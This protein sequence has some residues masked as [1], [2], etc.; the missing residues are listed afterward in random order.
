MTEYKID[1]PKYIIDRFIWV[2]II[3]IFGFFTIF[4]NNFLTPTNMINVMLHAS[5]LGL[6][7]IG[8]AVCLI[9][10]NFDLSAEGTVA[11]LTVLAAWLMGTAGTGVAGSFA[12]GSGWGLNPILVI[13]IMV[14]IGAFIGW[15]N[16]IMITRL[17]M[18]N[19]IVTLA[20]QL[21]LKGLSLTISK[22][23]NISGIPDAFRWLGTGKIGIIPVQII[24]T[25]LAIALFNFYLNKSRFGRQL[26]AT[27]G[28]RNAALASGF[29][30]DNTIIKSYMISG[31]MAAIA[32]WMLLGRIGESTLFLGA[33][34][35]L[36]TVAAAVIGGVAL[37]GGHGKIV[38][39]FAGVMLLSVVD[40]GLNLMSM[41]A[42]A[43]KLVRGLILLAALIIDAQK[44]RYKPKIA[45]KKT[46]K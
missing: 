27:G 19:F 15:L 35:T 9:G 45:R 1:W 4:A 30:P 29:K 46:E 5:V 7:L 6:M 11:L 37:S 2:V 22:G 8:Q 34:F 25:V 17:K 42:S 16:G 33:G 26:Y 41:D 39:A 21:T 28:N 43:V 3:L 10:G 14:A 24:V 18:N 20:M 31:V 36:E 40:N 13:L 12:A 44:H 32:A 23:K 38:G